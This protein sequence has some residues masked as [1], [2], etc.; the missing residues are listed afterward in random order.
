MNIQKS[1]VIE[2]MR[3]ITLKIPADVKGTRLI[4]YSWP[5]MLSTSSGEIFHYIFS[6]KLCGNNVL[7]GYFLYA[8]S[9]LLIRCTHGKCKLICT[10]MRSDKDKYLKTETIEL[11]VDNLKQVYLPE[12]VAWGIFS[13]DD[14]IEIQIQS[15]V[16][17]EAQLPLVF[18]PLC[19]D[20][21][22]PKEL[23]KTEFALG[24][25]QGERIGIEE[26][27]E[28]I[29]NSETDAEN[30]ECGAENTLDTD[31]SE[32]NVQQLS[33]P[34]SC[35]ITHKF[36]N[37]STEKIY[38]YY[39]MAQNGIKK[40]Y[41]QHFEMKFSSANIVRGFY[42][43]DAPW[44]NNQYFICTTGRC[45]VILFDLRDRSQTYLCHTSVILD[46]ESKD[47]LYFE[48]GIAYAV[49]SLEEN[50]LLYCM[51]DNTISDNVNRIVSVFDE[52]FKNELPCA[53]IISSAIDRLAPKA[54]ELAHNYW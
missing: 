12:G 22:L 19:S 15:T 51:S 32:I 47:S 23:E 33:I 5:L 53:G 3:I 21:E 6:R 44:T 50:T 13:L 27:N 2:N 14:E 26:Y 31:N 24:E 7:Y 54:E 43:Q 25:M 52:R 35:F 36:A 17:I 1:S 30:S 20:F 45:K 37:P 28:L 11:S 4:T 49:V 41:V 29:E 46:S 40:T 39:A 9:T 8:S 10:E 42:I 48:A 18:D 38:S 34:G 16:D